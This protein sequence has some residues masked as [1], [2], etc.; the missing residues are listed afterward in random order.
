MPL[1]LLPYRPIRAW[2]FLFL[3]VWREWEFLAADFKSS[4]LGLAPMDFDLTQPSSAL[5]VGALFVAGVLLG[6]FATR[7]GRQ[8]RARIRELEDQIDRVQEEY[9]AYR[10]GVAKHF[11]QTSDL[12]REL[13]HQYTSLY[14]HLAE[15]AR[16]LCGDL[17][18]AGGRGFG[19]PILTPSAEATGDEPLET[20]SEPDTSIERTPEPD[21]DPETAGESEAERTNAFG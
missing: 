3:D 19:A 2:S 11:D 1:V 14:A 4:V 7:A 6:I 16:D 20:S 12:F 15:G 21:T 5:I 13:T 10:S 17:L 18:P 9:T 8:A